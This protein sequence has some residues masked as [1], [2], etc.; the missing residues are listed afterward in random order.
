M[1]S[2][3][4]H[5]PILYCF[6]FKNRSLSNG[7]IMSQGTRSGWYLRKNAIRGMIGPPRTV[8]KR[9]AVEAACCWSCEKETFWR[10]MRTGELDPG[11]YWFMKGEKTKDCLP[12]RGL[13]TCKGNVRGHNSS[14]FT[15]L[16]HLSVPEICLPKQLVPFVSS[17]HH[18]EAHRAL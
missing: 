3:R 17:L 11:W 2:F 8:R 7:Q 6:S 16:G 1:S 13:S 14:K 18:K 12:L 5:W 4:P 10:L 15:I 9:Q